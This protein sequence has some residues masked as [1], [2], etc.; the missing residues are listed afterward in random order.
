M[1]NNQINDRDSRKDQDQTMDQ[2]IEEPPV[3]PSIDLDFFEWMSVTP[4]SV[5]WDSQTCLKLLRCNELESRALCPI[6]FK[7]TQAL[8]RCRK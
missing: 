3:L 1:S 5:V 7:L 2:L 8:L 4:S 6:Q